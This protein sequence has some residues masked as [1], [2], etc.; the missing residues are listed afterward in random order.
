MTSVFPC[1]T[2]DGAW[3]PR[4]MLLRGFLAQNVALGCAYGGFSVL[5][6]QQR[7]GSSRSTAAMG[8]ALV[9]L[10]FSGLGPLIAKLMER[11]GLRSMMMMGVVISG[12]GYVVLAFAPN[13]TV[14]LLTCAVL[15]GA[16]GAMFESFPSSVLSGSWY[17][18]KRGWAVGIT[19]IPLF[20]ALIPL[21]GAAVINQYGLP[22][23]FLCL[24]GLHISLLPI[25][26]GVRDAVVPGAPES[27]NTEEQLAVSD[28]HP[29]QIILRRP[30]F[31]LLVF[32]VGPLSAT[33]ITGISHIAALATEKGIAADRAALLVSV[34][35]SASILGSV[36]VGSVCDRIGG[37]RTLG[38]VALGFAVSWAVIASTVKL[39]LMIPAVLVIG[40]CGAGIFPSVNVVVAQVFG[41]SALPRAIGLWGLFTLPLTFCLPPA[42]GWLRDFAGSYTVMMIIIMTVCT[43]AA[44]KFFAAAGIMDRRARTRTIASEIS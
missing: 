38:L 15:I 22:A 39:P 20:I 12:S 10:M 17:P 31:W 4:F 1:I 5:A 30:V 37:L 28:D 26:A 25:L 29:W 42:A 18:D 40:A 33:A 11:L 19:G 21:L 14:V 2:R 6:L 27:I 34:M 13:M 41:L 7:F 43:I 8:L 32:G 23:F 36:L 9:V 44:I 35:G 24:A 16:G 3:R